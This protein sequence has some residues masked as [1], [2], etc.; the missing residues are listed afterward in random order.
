MRILR[1]MLHG[2]VSLEMIGGFGLP[3][4]IDETFRRLVKA[5]I[6]VVGVGQ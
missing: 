3:L 5:L 4:E 2:F 1:S 6:Q